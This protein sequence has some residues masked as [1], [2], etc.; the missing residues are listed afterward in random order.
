MHGSGRNSGFRGSSRGGHNPKIYDPDRASP[1]T[2]QHQVGGLDVTVDKAVGME[3]RQGTEKAPRPERN[4]SGLRMLEAD[5]FR[6][7]GAEGQFLH[8]EGAAGEG[9]GMGQRTLGH[10]PH[11]GGVVQPRQDGCLVAD[12]LVLLPSVHCRDL[13]R[14]IRAPCQVHGTEDFGSRSPAQAFPQLVLP[15]HQDAGFRRLHRHGVNCRSGAHAAKAAGRCSKEESCAVQA[16]SWKPHAQRQTG[17]SSVPAAS[18]AA[19]V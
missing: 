5:G 19:K 2:A 15:G 4:V 1:E 8:E 10:K 18:L 13:D 16:S 17:G 7:A 6:K 14:N 9:P 12:P 11:D 3:V